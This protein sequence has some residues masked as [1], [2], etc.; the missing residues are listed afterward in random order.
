MIK[1]YKIYHLCVQ[2][3]EY[4][5][6]KYNRDHISQVWLSPDGDGL[7]PDVPTPGSPGGSCLDGPVTPQLFDRDPVS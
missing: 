3:K 2:Y 7:A 6:Q 5:D 4:N 1:M